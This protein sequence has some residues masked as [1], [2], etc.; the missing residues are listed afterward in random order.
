MPLSAISPV[1]VSGKLESGPFAGMGI[2]T[3]V[4]QRYGPSCEEVK[5]IKK[6][7]FE[8]SAFEVS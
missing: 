7:N 6:G 5:K 2:S 8:G 1:S 4:S 3:S